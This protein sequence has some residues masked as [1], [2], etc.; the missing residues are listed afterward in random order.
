MADRLDV[1]LSKLYRGTIRPDMARQSIEKLYPQARK[2][3]PP[4]NGRRLLMVKKEE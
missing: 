4:T 2:V 1:I 3:A